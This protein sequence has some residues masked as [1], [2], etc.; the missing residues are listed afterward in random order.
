M[1]L[2]ALLDALGPSLGHRLT[3]AHL[4]HGLQPDHAAQAV[5]AARAHET[6][7]N[8]V[9][10]SLRLSPGP[11]LQARARTA[12]YAALAELAGT[13]GADAIATAHHADDQAET[14][15]MR[16]S[17]GAGVGAL[18]GIR[19]RTTAGVVR[20]LLSLDRATL[21]AVAAS[22]EVQWWED[23]SNA[24]P[25]YQ[26]NRMRHEVLPALSAV[27]PGAARGLTRTADN[28]AGHTEAM[29][30]WVASAVA[31]HAVHEG[32]QLR[33]PMELVP[34]SLPALA[35]LVHWATDQLGVPALSQAAVRQVCNALRTGQ[36]CNVHGLAVTPAGDALN[37]EACAPK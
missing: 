11:A 9:T 13:S 5:I 15:L 31:K 35:P 12:R 14:V 3:V 33:I 26:R 37:F 30:F 24:R 1:V 23:P 29:A 4:D 32:T 2:W 19:R 21:R 8:L 22:L 16:A 25:D 7:C 6:G 17:R 10:R 36:Q 34:R 18:A 28:A 20:P 27:A